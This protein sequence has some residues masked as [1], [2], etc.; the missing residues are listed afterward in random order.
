MDSTGDIW[1]DTHLTDIN[2]YGRVDRDYF[3]D[4]VVSSFGAPR[5]FVRRAAWHVLDHAWELEDRAGG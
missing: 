1:V 2:R 4:D 5:Y 3:I